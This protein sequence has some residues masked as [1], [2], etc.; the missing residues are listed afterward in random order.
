MRV[1][2]QL[3][4]LKFAELALKATWPRFHTVLRR[5]YDLVGNTLS[6]GIQHPILADAAYLLLKPFE[7]TSILVLRAFLAEA[8]LMAKKMYNG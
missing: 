6:Q 2:A 5:V 4:R 3:Q 8:D 7:W 1:N